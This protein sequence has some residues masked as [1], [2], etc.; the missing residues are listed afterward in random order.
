MG[1]RG[2]RIREDLRAEAKRL[3]AS[4][5]SSTDVTTALVSAFPE[6]F[7]GLDLCQQ[8]ELVKGNA[9]VYSFPCTL[10]QKPHDA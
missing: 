4:G 8:R 3:N 5:L 6:E 9:A 2:V 1:K 10:G 7:S